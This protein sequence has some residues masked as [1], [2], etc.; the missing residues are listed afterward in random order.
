MD[1]QKAIQIAE[2]YIRTVQGQYSK[3]EIV[4]SIR[5]EK[6]EVKDVDL[7]AIPKY[8]QNKK[9]IRLNYKDIQIDIYLATEG[10]FEC[11]RL[12]R[13]GSAEHNRMLCSLALQ[14]GWK[15]KASG[16]GLITK[17]KTLKVEKEIL[18]ALLG[19]YVE[20]KDREVKVK[21]RE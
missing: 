15:L 3:I 5:R 16:E 21:M 6:S 20:P 1:R 4:G 9:I 10:T 8:P 12:I 2:D 18:E 14:K 7:I 11:L 13:T 17:D 19:K